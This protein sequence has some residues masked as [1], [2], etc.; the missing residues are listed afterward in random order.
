MV[1]VLHAQKL[2]FEKAGKKIFGLGKVES[3]R[4]G[5][6]P[7]GPFPCRG[8][9]ISP[10]EDG[11]KEGGSLPKRERGDSLPGPGRPKVQAAA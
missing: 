10:G 1:S 8:R 4:A 3:R 7:G 6:H 11:E 2:A 5:A 9:R